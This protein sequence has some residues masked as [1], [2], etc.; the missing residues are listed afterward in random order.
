MTEDPE[1]RARQAAAVLELRGGS[2]ARLRRLSAAALRPSFDR[3]RGPLVTV[4][5]ATYNRSEVLRF[6]I[7]SVRRQTYRNWELIVVGDACT[8]DSEAVVGSFADPRIRWTNLPQN[9]GSQSGPN[10]LGIALASGTYVAYLGHDD[11]WLPQHLA[12]LASAAERA[13]SGL[14][15]GV[16]LSLGPPGSNIHWLQPSR[17]YEQGMNVPPSAI[18]HRRDL[19]DEVGGWRD[20]RDLV[21]PPDLEFITRMAASRCGWTQVDELTVCKFNAALRP[22]SYRER[23]SDE[24]RRALRRIVFSR[25]L[26]AIQELAAVKRLRDSGLEERP[27]AFRQPP[28]VMPAGWIVNEWRRVRGLDWTESPAEHSPTD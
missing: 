5:I 12:R 24:Q 6:A 23:R 14:A 28:A 18:L 26:F 4:V 8:D 3:R 25:R 13:G 20:Y 16:C 1:S 17:A 22:N 9:T 27:P 7:E 11:L 21:E 2:A 10:N 19:V 15:M